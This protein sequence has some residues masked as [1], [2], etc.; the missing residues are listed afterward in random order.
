MVILNVQLNSQ[1]LNSVINFKT[2]VGQFP[3]GIANL[4]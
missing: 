4:R 1:F 3:A 2:K